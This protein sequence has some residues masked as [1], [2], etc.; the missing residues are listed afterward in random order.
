MARSLFF[1]RFE[2]PNIADSLSFGKEWASESFVLQDI[3]GVLRTFGFTSTFLALHHLLHRHAESLVTRCSLYCSVSGHYSPFMALASAQRWH[4]CHHDLVVHHEHR[5]WREYHCLGQQRRW[6]C[7]RL[8]RHLYVL[9]NHWFFGISLNF[10][11]TKLIVSANV[12][13]PIATMC[14]CKHL[15]LVS[16]TRHVRMDSKDRQ[17]RIIFD[18]AMCFC[19][20]LLFMALRTTF[21]LLWTCLSLPKCRLRGARSPLWYHWGFRL[22]ARDI[23]ICCSSLSGLY[24]ATCILIGN[25]GLCR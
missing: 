25:F 17:R 21:I 8:V 3:M 16:S 24:P 23:C 22:S 20:P 4:T 19:L 15:E 6:F 11:A 7:T 10:L 5:L 12:A 18:S 2:G 14:I 1:L 13:L 9:G